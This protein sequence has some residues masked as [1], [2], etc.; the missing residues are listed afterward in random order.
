MTYYN[1]HSSTCF[2][3]FST[4]PTM[5][6]ITKRLLPHDIGRPRQTSFVDI[7]IPYHKD[8]KHLYRV[9]GMFPFFSCK[10]IQRAFTGIEKCSIV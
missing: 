4:S 10:G 2:F 9:G 5:I 6:S 1:R 7:F 8:R 3:C